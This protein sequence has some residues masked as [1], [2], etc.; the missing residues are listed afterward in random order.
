MKPLARRQLK[1]AFE[2]VPLEFAAHGAAALL[3]A[4][5][6]LGQMPTVSLIAWLLG[7]AGIGGLRL[8][9]ARAYL[10]RG[11]ALNPSLW[12]GAEALVNLVNGMIWG[13]LAFALIDL[14]SSTQVALVLLVSSACAIS[15][16][17]SASSPGAFPA[18]TLGMLAPWCVSL[19]MAPVAPSAAAITFAGIGVIFLGLF[20][21]IHRQANE[22]LHAQTESVKTP[23]PLV[24]K[25]PTKAKLTPITSDA[26]MTAPA[27]SATTLAQREE[28]PYAGVKRR[29]SDF[30]TADSSA[31]T[32]KPASS[33]GKIKIND[34]LVPEA[35][36]IDPADCT[37]LV[38][39]DNLD[40]QLVALH[41]LQKRGYR[42]VI[43]NN[44]REALSAVER[45]RFDL[46]LMDLQMPE[47]G[48]LEAT[49]AI[50]LKEKSS[51]NRVP[52]VALTANA[53]SESR[54]ICLAAGMDDYL[55]KPITRSRLFAS[56]DTQLRKKRRA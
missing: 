33:F 4:S 23:L 41:L 11:E 2:R 54:E 32:A 35:T 7:I 19:T 47:M 22:L 46:I 18:L 28:R 17:S 5:L 16:W 49:A 52:I 12:G 50:R 10:L 3:I 14:S 21:L 39:E 48:G 45:Q 9:M 53:A 27:I 51:A 40:N 43:A 1:L 29:A 31:S 8:L 38:V 55:S 26:W 36:P 37:I 30:R 44:G 24:N 34:I 13:L 42:V 20:F 6:I 56:L 15:L 25:E